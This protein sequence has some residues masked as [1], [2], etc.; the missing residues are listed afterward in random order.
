MAMPAS[1]LKRALAGD[2]KPPEITEQALPANTEKI[3]RMGVV[4][5]GLRQRADNNFSQDQV[6]NFSQFKTLQNNGSHFVVLFHC[7]IKSVE[8]H[9]AS[10]RLG[11][12]FRGPRFQHVVF[13]NVAQA[14]AYNDRQM[15]VF[16]PDHQ[17]E[18]LPIERRHS[19][20]KDDTIRGKGI[21]GR[22]SFIG[23]RANEALIIFFNKGF[24]GGLKERLVII[25]KQD[26]GFHGAPRFSTLNG[27]TFVLSCNSTVTEADSDETEFLNRYKNNLTFG[28]GYTK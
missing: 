27:N 24:L 25:H 6:L 18:V 22:E 28:Y 16:A 7:A 8:K 3:S 13:I 4:E 9:A 2:F 21:Y 11:E 5:V 17:Q 26:L 14:R 1:E 15:G 23:I 20:V 19:Y 12:N 10:E